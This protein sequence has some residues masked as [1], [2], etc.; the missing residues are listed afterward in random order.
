VNSHLWG[1]PAQEHSGEAGD[2]N[3]FISLQSVYFEANILKAFLLNLT[4]YVANI[5]LY[6]NI[7]L[8]VKFCKYLLLKEY[9]EANIRQYEKM[10]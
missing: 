9:F 7:I 3:G 2:G 8:N 4:Q 1:G 6:A 10:L 5:R